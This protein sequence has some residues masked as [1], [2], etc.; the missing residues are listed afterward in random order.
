MLQGGGYRVV[1]K[2]VSSFDSVFR[3]RL[4]TRIEESI[5]RHML[6]LANGEARPSKNSS[7][8]RTTAEA[9]ENLVGYIQALRDVVGMCQDVEDDL[10]GREKKK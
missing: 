4:H 1:S 9:Y 10:M 2:G 6:S 8:L 3:T 5:E 7:T